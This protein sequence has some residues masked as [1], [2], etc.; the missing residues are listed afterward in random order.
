MPTTDDRLQGWI[1]GL[2]ERS[3]QQLRGEVEQLVQAM[4]EAATSEHGEIARNA[5]AEAEAAGAAL[6]AEAIEAERR[7]A[8]QRQDEA[9]QAS[10]IACRSEHARALADVRAAH[11]ATLERLR[12]EHASALEALHVELDQARAVAD[13]RAEDQAR[14]ATAVASTPADGRHADLMSASSLLDAVRALDDASSLTGILERLS[15]QAARHTPRSAVVLVQ[16]GRV[17]GWRWT[18]M[19]GEATDLDLPVDDRGLVAT[20]ARTGLT[21]WAA[22]PA[23]ASVVL[24]PHHEGRAGV[25]VP[26]LLDKQAVAVLYG[27]DDLENAPAVPG[28]WPELVEVLA[29]HAGRCLEAMTARKMPDL[30]KASAAERARRRSIGHEEEAAQRCARLLVAEIKLY[31]ETT[32]EEAR[33]RGDILRRLRPQ[34]ERAQQLYAER[35]PSGIRDR[36]DYFDQEL[37]RTLAGG[38]PALLGQAL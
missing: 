21:Q 33:Q 22:S 29:R 36:T 37:V 5:R 38:D 35:V 13:V 34:I 31:H 4:R 28:T 27:D 17:R 15:E 3:G 14:L 26:V 9:V 1:E 24:A 16:N 20:A 12:T 18:G 8:V 30:L 25:A 23:P 2:L 32:V 7:V 6:A 19:P 10:L 11:E